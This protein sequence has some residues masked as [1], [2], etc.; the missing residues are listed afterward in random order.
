MYWTVQYRRSCC[1]VP[2]SA[3]RPPVLYNAIQ[4]N[5]ILYCTVTPQQ[6]LSGYRR[7]CQGSFFYFFILFFNIFKYFKYFIVNPW[8]RYHRQVQY[9]VLSCNVCNV[10]YNTA[11]YGA[12]LYSAV[13]HNT[14]Q[15][16]IIQEIVL[17]WTLQYRRS[18]CTVPSSTAR[19]PVLYNAI[20]YNIV[21]YSNTTTTTQ[22]LPAILPGEV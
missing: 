17:Y 19:P 21:L 9:I 18:C 4:Y 6:Q 5:T 10:N 20:Q 7:S 22:W 13:L 8:P 2:S 15:Y 11:Q 16:C 1:T 14:I 3:A 12:L